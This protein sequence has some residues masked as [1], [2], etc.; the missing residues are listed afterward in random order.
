MQ[1]IV[2]IWAILQ[3]FIDPPLSAVVSLV[4][5]GVGGVDTNL[6]LPVLY[7]SSAVEATG[8]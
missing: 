3:I 1:S 2:L 7:V 6:K 8:N 5:R 4:G